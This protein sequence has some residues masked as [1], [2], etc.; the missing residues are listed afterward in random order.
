MGLRLRPRAG[1][2]DRKL[3]SPA[4][5]APAGLRPPGGPTARRR[6]GPAASRPPPWPPPGRLQRRRPA[7]TLMLCTAPLPL[8]C[9][10]GRLAL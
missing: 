2:H 3:G 8:H 7:A 9:P 10:T 1:R 4:T 5:P 6:P